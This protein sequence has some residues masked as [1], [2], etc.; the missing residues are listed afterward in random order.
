MTLGHIDL[1][2]SCSLAEWRGERPGIS[3]IP[4]PHKALGRCLVFPNM[5]GEKA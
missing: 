4:G 2:S 3:M 5:E 1:C